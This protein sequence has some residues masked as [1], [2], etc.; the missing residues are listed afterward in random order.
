MDGAISTKA[1]ILTF[2]H[3]R[4]VQNWRFFRGLTGAVKEAIAVLDS[5][6]SDGAVGKCLDQKLHRWTD[7]L[8]IRWRWCCLRAILWRSRHVDSTRRSRSRPTLRK[9]PHHG[10][11]RSVPR[12][13]GAVPPRIARIH[14][15]RWRS[16][17]QRPRQAK[18]CRTRWACRCEREERGASEKSCGV[19]PCQ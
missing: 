18:A 6:G 10:E 14:A 15:C 17:R 7:V 9:A 16:S 13:R 4:H 5:V 2:C 8:R 12:P 19:N 3:G 11:G 1:L